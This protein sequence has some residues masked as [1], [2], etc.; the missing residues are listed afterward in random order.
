VIDLSPAHTEGPQR[1]GKEC[2]NVSHDLGR[3][4]VT[5]MKKVLDSVA[6]AIVAKLDYL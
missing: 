5:R 1:D 2:K 6:D 4:V 3:V